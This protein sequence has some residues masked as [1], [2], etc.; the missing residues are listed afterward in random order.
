VYHTFCSAS[1]GNLN[2]RCTWPARSAEKRDYA[3]VRWACQPDRGALQKPCYPPCHC[4]SCLPSFP[5]PSLP[6]RIRV[7]PSAWCGEERNY[8]TAFWG[9]ASGLAAKTTGRCRKT[10]LCS[11][12]P[13]KS[14]QK[15]ILALQKA[16][17]KK[18]GLFLTNCAKSD[19]RPLLCSARTEYFG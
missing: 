9:R 7:N 1:G 8:S 12:K 13:L 10:R 2:N 19:L 17:R 3:A 6:C 18:L 15:Q 14:F 16:I 5:S 4:P 11:P